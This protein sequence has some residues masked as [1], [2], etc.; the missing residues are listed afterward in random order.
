MI[1][2]RH[3]LEYTPGEIADLLE[4]PRGT[5]NSR[6]RRGLDALE[7]RAGGASSSGSRSPASTRR[8]SA[9]GSSSTPPSPS[10]SRGPRRGAFVR[11][12][13]VAAA[14]AVLVAAALSPPGR[15]V[16]DRVRRGDRR[17]ERGRGALLASRRRAA[18]RHVELGRV[19]RRGRRVEAAPRRL[20]RGVVV[21]VR[22]VRRG[23]AGERARRARARTG[24]CAGSCRGRG[25]LPAL[26]RLA[27]RHADRVR[28]RQPAARRRRRRPGD[29]D[30]AAH[31]P[32]HV[33]PVWRPGRR[34]ELTYLDTAACADV[35]DRRPGTHGARSAF[36]TREA[37]VVAA[38]RPAG[39][40]RPRPDRRPLGRDGARHAHARR[41]RR[42]V[43]RRRTAPDHPP[44]RRAGA[45]CSST[46]ASAS[47]APDV[48]RLAWSP[49]GAWVLVGWRDPTSGCSSAPP[50]HGA[51]RRRERRAAVRLAERSPR[52][53]GGAARE[54][55]R[56]P[57]R[58]ARSRSHRRRSPE[59]LG[60]TP[61]ALVT[62]DLESHVVAVDVVAGRV[63]REIP[64]LADPR[65]IEPVGNLAVVGHTEQG[66]SRSS[67]ARRSSAPRDR[68]LRASRATRPPLGDDRHALVTDSGRRHARRH[69][70]RRPAR[71]SRP[72]PLGGRRG[73]SPWTVGRDRAIVALGTR[74]SGSRSSTSPAGASA[75][76]A[77]LRAA[78]PR[79]RRRVRPGRRSG[80]RRAT[81]ASSRLRARPV[82][83]RR[84]RADAP[85]QHVTFH[86]GRAYVTSGDDGTLRVH[87]A[88]TGASSS[89]LVALG[90]YNVQHACS[91]R[92]LMTLAQPGH[93]LHRRR[94]RPRHAPCG[95]HAPPTTPAS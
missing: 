12:L 48:H 32:A 26:G 37:R 34:F 41:A 57:R 55:P 14:L 22:A 64:T 4:L 50:G 77:P 1:V 21:A 89:A 85:P 2:L 93:A 83:A 91:G 15:A 68:R 79:P 20:R 3:L 47:R 7:G 42:R 18:A 80:S 63:L 5:V 29:V 45:T 81:R 88:A 8:A 28:L 60:G 49:D 69:R 30:A 39:R 46:A 62:A 17:G 59:R 44:R 61:T 33:E 6:L 94:T 66:A 82:V 38:R 31:A 53:D 27:D 56:V 73:T 13:L 9:R 24:T 16:I 72:R 95:S 58:R 67:T 75:T 86:R 76:R 43:R 51:S 52:I 92:I 54:P 25:P 65:S 10:A 71:R 78:V 36:R 74:P 35:P 87:S 11:P 90:S 23:L 40:R 19:G 70:R 84:L